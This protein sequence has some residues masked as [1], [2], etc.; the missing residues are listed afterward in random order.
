[1]GLGKRRFVEGKGGGQ[2][3]GGVGKVAKGERIHFFYYSP[4]PQQHILRLLF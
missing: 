4:F 1:M 2:G 3:G